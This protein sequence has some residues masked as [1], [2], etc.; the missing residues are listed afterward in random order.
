[1]ATYCLFA[2]LVLVYGLTTYPDFTRL[3]IESFAVGAMI[4]KFVTQG[5]YWRIITANLLHADF[6]HLLNNVF[7]VVIFGR[8]LEPVLGAWRM[9]GLFL[10]TGTSAMLASWWLLPESTVGAS[11]IDFGL[12]GCYF[13]LVL[14]AR[15]QQDLQTFW[16]ELRSA[17]VF[18]VVFVVWNLLEIRQV[19]LVGHLGGLLS[20]VLVGGVYRLLPGKAG[21]KG[22]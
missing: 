1:M 21:A 20:G 4:P 14:M 11:G 9:T 3:G 5:E 10:V 16:M 8:F 7:G 12:I 2:L 22:A 17:L 18:V 6:H 13:T 15:R 19:N